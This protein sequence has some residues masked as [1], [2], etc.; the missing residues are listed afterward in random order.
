[1]AVARPPSRTGTDHVLQPAPRVW[2]EGTRLVVSLSGEQDMNT[3][4]RLAAVLAGAAVEG[5]GDLVVDLSRV[6]FMDTKIVMVLVRR[7]AALRSRA[8]D[9]T[10]LAPSEFA[11]RVLHMCGLVGL[12]DPALVAAVDEIDSVTLVD[13]TPTAATPHD[14]ADQPSPQVVVI[15]SPRAPAPLAAPVPTA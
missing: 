15:P 5:D 11:R 6:E 2:R 14:G 8:R 13:G 1:M 3:A 4:P 10:L 7:R 12:A 9:L